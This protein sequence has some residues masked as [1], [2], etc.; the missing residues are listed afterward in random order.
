[1]NA[2]GCTIDKRM[3]DNE[4]SG[5][6]SVDSNSV[7]NVPEAATRDTDN[8]I[9]ATSEIESDSLTNSNN[10]QLKIQTLNEEETAV[11]AK[12]FQPVQNDDCTFCERN[13]QFYV[14]KCMRLAGP[15]KDRSSIEKEGEHIAR[16]VQIIDVGATIHEQEAMALPEENS[17]AVICPRYELQKAIPLSLCGR[18]V[19][20]AAPEGGWKK[21]IE[22]HVH[23]QNII[24]ASQRCDKKAATGSREFYRYGT[25][26]FC[27][28][29]Q[30][31]AAEVHEDHEV[32]AVQGMDREGYVSRGY[33]Q[34]QV[35]ELL[36]EYREQKER[37]KDK[38][39]KHN[40]EDKQKNVL[41]V[42]ESKEEKES[43]KIENGRTDKGK[44][45]EKAVGQ[46][47]VYQK[48][49][50]ENKVR[51]YYVSLFSSASSP[52]EKRLKWN[53]G[54][55]SKKLQNKVLES[56]QY[57]L[58]GHPSENDVRQIEPAKVRCKFQLIYICWPFEYLR[59]FGT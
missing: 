18:S 16:N 3:S 24:A 51:N 17:G 37:S 52:A 1:M 6:D 8:E 12:P 55:H 29:N 25:T 59:V 7:D 20:S 53:Y 23:D 14:E 31:G 27:K 10:E 33:E 11:W 15:N 30:V 44:N 39:G 46:T 49:I 9:P 58:F 13:R 42:P 38:K 21:G 26:V 41:E 47:L 22:F 5:F 32:E 43:G 34:S 40:E 54:G 45:K 28:Y 56:Q 36:P 48:K 35:N 2:I 19:T 57:S 50:L 4:S